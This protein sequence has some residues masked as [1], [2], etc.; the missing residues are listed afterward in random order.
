MTCH[1]ISKP[2]VDG[3]TFAEVLAETANQFPTHDALIFP[4]FDYRRTYEEF[5][6]DVQEVA[7]ALM[8]IGVEAG[9]HVGVWATNRPQWV[10]LQFAAASMGAV[11]VN[12]N[13]A[14]RAHELEY[15][16]NQAD[17]TTLFLVDQF[18]SSSFFDIIDQVCPEL[19]SSWP[20]ELRAKSCPRLRHVICITDQKRSGMMN[21]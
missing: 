9:E 14:Y 5:R 12:I 10:L 2:W 4:Q 15:V 17:I 1:E 11:L 19:H 3:L 18:K 21:W 20:G 6:S 8:A 16:L 13:P 7:R